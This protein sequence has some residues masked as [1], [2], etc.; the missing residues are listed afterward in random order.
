MADDRPVSSAVADHVALL[1]VVAAALVDPAGRVLLQRRPPGR[2]MADLWEFPGGKIEPGETPEAA[3]ARELAEELAITVHP[4][5]ATPLTF[6]SAGLGNRH[7]LLLLYVIRDWQGEPQ[8]LEASALAWVDP[9]AMHALAMPP[10][11]VPLVAM[12]ERLLGPPQ[13]QS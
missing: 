12:L 4:A 8:P 1:P 9:A 6:A 3:L 10:A 2:Q 13:Q 11:D 5:A 7:L